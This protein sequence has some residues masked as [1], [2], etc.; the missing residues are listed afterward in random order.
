M[1]WRIP[2]DYSGRF[3]IFVAID[4]IIYRLHMVPTQL[5]VIKFNNRIDFSDI[6]LFRGGIIHM[7]ERENGT[8][9]CLFHNHLEEKFRWSYPLIQYKQIDGNA[10]L[11]CIGD[12]IEAVRDFFCTADRTWVHHGR[13]E[14]LEIN[15]VLMED[16]AFDISESQIPYSLKHWIPLNSANYDKYRQM[17]SLVERV[18]FLE[19]IL[20]ANVLSM[21]KGLG[22]R[23]DSRI[24]CTISNLSEPEL[25]VSKSVRMMSFDASFKANIRLPRYIGLG[26]HVSTGYGMIIIP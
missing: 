24:T 13:E 1:D 3:I 26:K 18:A 11:V 17:E 14:R 21:A 19:G 22:T 7:I 16:V 23:L 9:N 12:G 8:V 4:H 6:P 2:F 25:L 10:S 5:L 20:T 15:D